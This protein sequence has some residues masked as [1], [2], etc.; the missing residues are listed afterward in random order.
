MRVCINLDRRPDRWADALKE[1]AKQD[2]HVHRFAAVDG[3]T[4]RNPR[5]MGNR[6]Q[7]ACQLSHRLVMRRALADASREDRGGTPL[8]RPGAGRPSHVMIFEDDVVL[9]PGFRRVVE[10][11]PP[12]EDWGLLI[13]GCTH[14]KPPKVTDCKGWV[15]VRDFWGTHAVAVRHEWI[16]FLLR[17]LRKPVAKGGIDNVYSSLSGKIPIYA[18]HPN[19]AWQRA[20]FS[21]IMKKDK[22][23]YSADGRQL[24]RCD[25]QVTGR[26]WR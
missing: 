18:M 9:H 6:Y 14:V 23:R 4:V 20:G 2:L 17:E 21:D 24:I 13:F 11:H 3:E 7:Y 16:P 22:R 15:K 5:R 1:F 10:G 26:R 8:K 19:V 25:A 12:P